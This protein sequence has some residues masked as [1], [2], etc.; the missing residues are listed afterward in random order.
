MSLFKNSNISTTPSNKI[1]GTPVVPSSN[2]KI[3]RSIEVNPIWLVCLLLFI[4]FL[5]SLNYESIFNLRNGV[6][7]SEMIAKKPDYGYKGPGYGK[8]ILKNYFT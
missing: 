5:K 8:N 6:D 7:Y 2:G 4:S 3:S 1:L